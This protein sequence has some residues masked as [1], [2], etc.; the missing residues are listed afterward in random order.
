MSEEIK[1]LTGL[2]YL[3]VV[4]GQ[5]ERKRKRLD[6]DLDMVILEIARLDREIEQKQKEAAKE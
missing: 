1:K 4:R 3:M 2:R 6:L 5:K